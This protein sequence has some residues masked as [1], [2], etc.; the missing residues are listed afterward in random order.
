MALKCETGSW[1]ADSS[2]SPTEHTVTLVDSTLTPKY[3]LILCTD[4]TSAGGFNANC[5]LALGMVAIGSGGGARCVTLWSADAVNTS[6]CSGGYRSTVL[7]LQSAEVT[8]KFSLSLISATAGSFNVTY[9][10]TATNTIFLY[11]VLGDADLTNQIVMDWTMDSVGA[12]EVLTGA[13]FL[14]GAVICAS[15]DTPTLGTLASGVNLA[16]GFASSNS[17]YVSGSLTMT[18]GDTMTSNMNWNR[19]FHTNSCIERLTYNADTQEAQWD[20][21][22]FDNDGATFGV[23]DAPTNTDREIILTF[24]KGGTYEA[25]N[26][27]AATTSGNQTVNLANSSLTPKGIIL[28]TTNQT[29]VG[30]S[31]GTAA[32]CIGFSDGTRHRCAAVGAVEAIATTC[33][34]LIATDAAIEELAWGASPAETRLGTVSFNAGNFVI[35]WSATGA[36]NL[37]GY[38]VCGDTPS[39]PVPGIFA[40]ATY[41]IGGAF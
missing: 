23:V 19:G 2:V 6:S 29:A 12:T 20:I 24:L 30:I 34:R 26:F 13:G 15:S 35:N 18:D 1:V 17:R 32:M 5:S 37:Y 28:F 36:A 7:T 25:G 3:I 14:P 33:D 31:A 10:A 21:D 8:I 27:A 4:Q 38:F 9:S 39:G 40:Q 22:S 41:M 11:F 16:I